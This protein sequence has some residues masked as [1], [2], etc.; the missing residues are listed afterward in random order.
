MNGGGEIKINMSY[1]KNKRIDIKWLLPLFVFAAG[2]CVLYFIAHK[3]SI[4]EQEQIRI[5]AELNAVTYADRMNANLNEGVNITNSLKQILIS[6]NG[7]IGKFDAVA[8][9]M[10]TDYVQSIQLAPG[11]VVTEIYPEKGNEAGKIDL[12]HD[13]KR[14]AIVNYGIENRMI[15]MQG[16]FELKQG[17]YGIAIRNPVYLVSPNGEE[18]FW[19]LTIVIIRVPEIFQNSVQALT[20]FGYRYRLYKTESP[21]DDELKLIDSSSEE[22]VEP[23]S[24]DFELGGCIWKLEV[25]PENGWIDIKNIYR[26]SGVGIVIILLIEGLTAAFLLME[27]QRK[28]FKLLAVTDG[29]TGLLNRTGFNKQMDS[30]RSH[31]LEL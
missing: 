20:N 26:I 29:L 5:K 25:M 4:A 9:N 28:N 24:H 15:V 16:P 17:G 30:R 27:E 18:Y 14:G 8:A 3:A 2:V 23:V 11:G 13:E 6:E 1:D 10:M 31:A 19:G 21:L 7:K 12:I 22:L